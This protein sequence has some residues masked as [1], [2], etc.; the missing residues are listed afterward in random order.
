MSH[1]PLPLQ[2]IK[3][4]GSLLDWSELPAAFAAWE[5]C[6]LPARRWVVV[7]GGRRVDAI[8][9]RDR[10]QRLGAVEAHWQAIAAM[11][12]NAATVTSVCSLPITHAWAELV[13]GPVR[14]ETRLITVTDFL[15]HHEPRLPGT[16]L[17]VTWSATSDSIAA[18]VAICAQADELVLLKSTDASCSG[19][20]QSRLL[21]KSSDRWSLAKRQ[22]FPVSRAS[23][24]E[25]SEFGLIDSFLPCLAAELPALRIVNLR[26]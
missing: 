11:D 23:L 21:R 19:L 14:P 9:E 26:S 3:L 13:A 10:R 2:V 17:P 12:Q 20:L 16:R 18:R 4:G 24:T 22:G 1:A 25:L 15:R 8:R 6:E 7:G 5:A